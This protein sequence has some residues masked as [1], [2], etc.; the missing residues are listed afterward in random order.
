MKYPYLKSICFALMVSVLSLSAASAWAHHSVTMFEPKKVLTFDATVK[1]FQWTNPHSWLQVV[2]N[3]GKDGKTAEWS[4][5]MGP[6][7][8]LW[9]SGWKPRMLKE[10]D[11]VKVSLHPLKDG[12][13]GGRLVSVTL[14]D[15]R[16]MGYGGGNAA[17]GA[18]AG[19]D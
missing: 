14:P 16:V 13:Y 10:G 5:E 2:A 3:N 12:T 1:E 19:Q 11:K 7:V 4:L 6:S 17:P 18:G 8:G 9:R 15:G